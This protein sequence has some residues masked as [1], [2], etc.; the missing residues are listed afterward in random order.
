MALYSDLLPLL[1]KQVEIHNRLIEIEKDKTSAL[2]SGDVARLDSLLNLE[3][4]FVMHVNALGKQH[5]ALLAELGCGGD[6]RR[7]AG[8][9]GEAGA[10]SADAAMKELKTT[11]EKLRRLVRTNMGI[12]R[13]RLR[14]INRV[15]DICGVQNEG[16]TYTSG[17]YLLAPSE[18]L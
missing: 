13:A 2:A 11:A 7:P 10:E 8:E 18:N 14:V 17:G 6:L 4:P 5:E 1:E 16:A 12:L 9:D 3:Q 15:L